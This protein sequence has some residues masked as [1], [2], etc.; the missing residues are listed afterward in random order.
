MKVNLIAWFYVFYCCGLFCLIQPERFK[1]V[2]K[3]K[4]V[5]LSTEDTAVYFYS[6]STAF[7]HARWFLFH[8]DK[9]DNIQVCDGVIVSSKVSIYPQWRWNPTNLRSFGGCIN[10]PFFALQNVIIFQKYF[11]HWYFLKES[12]KSQLSAYFYSP[13]RA[14]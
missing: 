3:T 8:I 6:P 12:F 1:L 4:P 10:T 13:H 5:V 14:N 2:L 11:W 9:D 7:R